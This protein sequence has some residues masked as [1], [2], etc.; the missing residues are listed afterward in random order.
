LRDHEKT[1]R[2]HAIV[3]HLMCYNESTKSNLMVEKRKEVL[4]MA[5]CTAKCKAT[6]ERC[7][8]N[9]V[10]GYTVCQ[11]HGAGAPRKGRAGGRPANHNLVTVGRYSKHLP[12]RLVEDYEKSLKDPEL[13]NL[14]DEI[15]IIDTRIVDVMGRVDSGEAGTLWHKARSNFIDMQAAIAAQ[16][17]EDMQRSINML[18]TVLGQ[19]IGDWHAWDEVTKLMEQR[20]RLVESERK[21]LVEMNQVIT[22]ERALILIAAIV[23]IIKTHV[24]EKPTLKAITW[25]IETLLKFGN[26]RSGGDKVEKIP[27]VIDA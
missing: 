6:G 2:D 20:R 17:V 25:E 24:I 7:K 15:S 5:K 22:S 3:A 13:L 18:N 19:G 21:R 8:R 1:L 23:D 9:A 12:T 11:V 26:D 4:K 14:R 10:T 16:N 27:E